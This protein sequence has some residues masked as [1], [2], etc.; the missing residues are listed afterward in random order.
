MSRKPLEGPRDLGGGASKI[1]TINYVAMAM[2]ILYDNSF[3][4]TQ[5][6][7]FSV[8]WLVF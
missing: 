8:S 3:S 7:N 5:I 4:L 1:A 6:S 2:A